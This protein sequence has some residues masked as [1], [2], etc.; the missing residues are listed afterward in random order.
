MIH[1]IIGIDGEKKLCAIARKYL[2][3]N[4]SEG[5]LLNAILQAIAE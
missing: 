5:H 2:K 4:V 1:T 3:Q